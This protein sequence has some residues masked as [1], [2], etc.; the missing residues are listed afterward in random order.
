[1]EAFLQSQK[2]HNKWSD[3]FKV[4]IFLCQSPLH[5]R[6]YS[7]DLNM[8][9]RNVSPNFTVYFILILIP[10]N[11]TSSFSQYGSINPDYM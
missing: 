5:A 4:V 2:S 1:M 11:A 10:V 6:S 3:R 8:Q 7:P 9:K